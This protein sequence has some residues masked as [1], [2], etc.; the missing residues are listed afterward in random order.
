MKRPAVMNSGRIIGMW[1][2]IATLKEGDMTEVRYPN[3]TALSALSQAASKVTKK[4]SALA[5]SPAIQ[6]I[7]VTKIIVYI[8][9]NGKRTSDLEITQDQA[10]YMDD[11]ISRL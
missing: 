2:A 6:Y 10:L 3:E 9:S 1:R 5:S 4:L 11:R 7:R 8:V